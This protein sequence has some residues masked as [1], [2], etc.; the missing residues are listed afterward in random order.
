MKRHLYAC[1]GRRCLDKTIIG[2]HADNAARRGNVWIVV[3]D[4]IENHLR[5]IAFPA[6][7]EQLTGYTYNSFT[8][9]SVISGIPG[10]ID[11]IQSRIRP[12]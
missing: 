11:V 10:A 12:T 5:V 2:L 3:K 4:G 6:D 9:C 8:Y 1:C 7:L